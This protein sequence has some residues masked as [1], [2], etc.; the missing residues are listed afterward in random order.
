MTPIWIFPAY[1][2]LLLGPLASN[3]I[4]AV[5]DAAAAARINS[6]AIALTAVTIQGAG[7]MLSLMIYS[8]FIYRLMTRKLPQEI[9]RPGVFV[10]VGPSGFTVA[11]IVHLG[12][13]LPKI[14]PAN[15]FWVSEDS[16]HAAL[17]LKILADVVG[18]WLWGLCIWYAF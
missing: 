14:L 3:L 10:S 7:F 9:A 16:N 1:P 5:P 6:L 12:N 2:L 4:D 15:F 13:V 8:A 17:L 11:G 18:L